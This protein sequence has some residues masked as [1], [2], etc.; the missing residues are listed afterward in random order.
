MNK[1]DLK[2]LYN[3]G[4]GLYVITSSDG[5]RDN[6]MIGNTVMQVA[7]DPLVVAVSINKSNYSY[8]VIKNTGIMNVNCLSVSATFDVFKKFGFQSGRDVDKFA[9]EN[10]L[11]TENGLVRL[12]KNVNAVMSLKVKE[13]ID[14]GSHGMFLCE[15]TEAK[16]L[17]DEETMSYTYYQ[18]NV[19]PKPEKKKVKGY[20]CKI[21]GYVYEGAELPEDFVCPWCKHPASDFEPIA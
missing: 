7:S 11:R 17:S 14:I 3:I 10:L 8:E 19:K 6:G 1:E 13:V 21:C 4:Y 5:K 15:V 18:K 20:V 12:E 2:A 9:G 16:K